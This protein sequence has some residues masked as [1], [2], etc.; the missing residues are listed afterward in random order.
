MLKKTNIVCK[1]NEKGNTV[2]ECKHCGKCMPAAL[3]AIKTV[4][5]RC[6]YKFRKKITRDKK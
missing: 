5:A 2:F 4:C 6:G 1:I 3:V